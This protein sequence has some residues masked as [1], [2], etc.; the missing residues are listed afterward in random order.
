MQIKWNNKPQKQTRELTYIKESSQLWMKKLLKR[1][2]S[3]CIEFNF[4]LCKKRPD[5]ERRNIS[6]YWKEMSSIRQQKKDLRPIYNSNDLLNL[7]TEM[8]NPNLKA[9]CGSDHSLPAL[10]QLRLKWLSFVDVKNRFATLL[11]AIINK[12]Q[13]ENVFEVLDSQE[14]KGAL[15]I[16]KTGCPPGNR[17]SLWK[18]AVGLDEQRNNQN[19]YQYM[20]DLYLEY[21][22]M[23]D[24][25]IEEDIAGTVT[26][27]DQYFVFEEFIYQIL[28]PFTRDPHTIFEFIQILR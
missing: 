3:L 19:Y 24:S 9:D 18:L 4:T 25:I 16:C 2:N 13:A 7:I 23:I 1:I 14:V 10:L 15:E 21:E 20:K 12:E 22:M 6:L 5:Q 11:D 8:R 28:L 26:N 17:G 27:D